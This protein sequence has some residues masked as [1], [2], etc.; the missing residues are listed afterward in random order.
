[1]ADFTNVS[2]S[3]KTYYGTVSNTWKIED[4][5]IIMDVEIPANTTATVYIPA[6]NANS[7]REGGIAIDLIKD[8]KIAGTE[9]G[10]VILNIGSGKYHFS[11]NQ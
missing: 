10:Y 7:V 4:N 1:M 9:D 11:L 2:A 6:G 5:K 3:L 8:I